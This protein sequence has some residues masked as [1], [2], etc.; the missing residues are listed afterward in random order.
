M[1][2]TAEA[3]RALEPG[4][5]AAW[6]RRANDWELVDTRPEH[7][8]TWRKPVG[9]EGDS[10]VDLPLDISFRDYARRT[11]EI[12]DTTAGGVAVIAGQIDDKPRKVLVP[13]NAADY[14][15][16]IRAHE[17]GQFLR[18][19]GEL[20]RKGPEGTRAKKQGQR[21]HLERVRHVAVVLDDH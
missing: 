8:A 21:F 11:Y 12:L 20:V 15:L 1:S 4:Q 18:C 2:I 5:A 16:A 6:L 14:M 10:W 7:T 17:E 13:M 3:L 9:D 19:E